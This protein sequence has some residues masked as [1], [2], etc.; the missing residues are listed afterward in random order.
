MR[1]WATGG[2]GRLADCFL[3]SMATMQLPAMGYVLRCNLPIGS[4]RRQVRR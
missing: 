4:D 2:F 1:A 3:D